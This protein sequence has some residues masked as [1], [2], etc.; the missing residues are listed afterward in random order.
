MKRILVVYASRTG[1]TKEVAGEIA[2]QMSSAPGKG[3]EIR[4]EAHALPMGG[5]GGTANSAGAETPAPP[6]PRDW[7]AVVV[8][9]PVNGM[10]W[11]PEALSFVERNRAALASRPT[12]YF[13][14]SVALTG[15]G[16]FTK[17]VRSC[18]DPAS[19][20]AKPVALGFFGG[21]MSA[22][23]PAV[24]RFFFGLRKDQPKD[25]RD[26]EAIGRWARETADAFRKGW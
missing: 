9:A 1:S 6:D 8:G 3:E 19:A 23:P 17:K 25:G 16:L 4:A 15:K 12:A 11:L 24:L 5:P 22:Q 21:Y 20:L 10:R 7:D 13:L 26:W 18:L 14:L 2:R